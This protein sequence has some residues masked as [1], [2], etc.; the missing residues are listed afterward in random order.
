MIATSD[1][2]LGNWVYDGERTQFPMYVQAIGEDYV[3]LNFEGNEGDVWECKPEELQGIKLTKDILE[4]VGFSYDNGYW[5]LR[6]NEDTYLEYYPHEYRLRRWYTGV[7]EWNNHATVR[8]ITFECQC[9]YLHEF[10]NAFYMATMQE[11]KIKL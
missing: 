9:H 7:D 8:E 10:Q 11:L 2:R 5:R 4:K 6:T 1:L 3:Y